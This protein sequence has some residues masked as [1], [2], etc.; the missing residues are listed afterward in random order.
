[1]TT[2]AQ[3]ESRLVN[4]FNQPLSPVLARLFRL[5][6]VV[7]LGLVLIIALTVIAGFAFDIQW[8]KHPFGNQP[9]LQSGTAFAFLFASIAMLLL[10]PPLRA[11]VMTVA[12]KVMGGVVFC[13]GLVN[14]LEH[15]YQRDWSLSYPL[16]QPADATPLTFP[17]PIAPDVSVMFMILGVGIALIGLDYKNKLSLSQAC[18]LLV[19]LPNLMILGCYGFGVPHI[20]GFFGCLKFSPVTAFVFAATTFSALLSRP[21]EGIVSILAADTTGGDLVR[22]IALCLL[23][24]VP[25]LALIKAGSDMEFYDPI[26]AY[27]LMALLFSVVVTG[28]VMRSIKKVDSLEAEKTEIFEKLT[29]SLVNLEVAQKLRLKTVCLV[30]LK[31]YDD[32]SFLTCP[33]DGSELQQILDE[34]KPGSVF[35]TNYEI[36]RCLGA[37]GMSA[38]YL[39]KHKHMETLVAIKLVHAQFASDPKYVQRFKREAQATRALVHPHIAQTHDFGISNQGLAYLVMDFIDGI[40]LADRVEDLGPMPWQ[41]AVTIFLQICQGL[42]FAHANNIVHR[43]LKPANIMLAKP[44]TKDLTAKIVDFGL[45]KAHEF[46]SQKLTRTGEVLGSPIYMSPEQCRGEIVDERSDIYSMGTL[47]YEVLTGGPPFCGTTIFDTLNLQIGALPPEMPVNLDIPKWLREVVFKALEKAPE[48]RQQSIQGMIDEINAG[49]H[50]EMSSYLE[51][52]ERNTLS[53]TDAV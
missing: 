52:I 50:S 53:G 28:G 11:S 3:T 6:A 45:A 14:F 16:W 27:G 10:Y 36:D 46:G 39:A 19:L 12:A 49:M 26:I 23:P 13:L 25:A 22:Y 9:S 41:E 32:A 35:A 47:M 38:V 44:G 29:S 8:I 20:C 33:D 43:D 5:L 51:R 31:E 7:G 21:K 2:A 34:L 1:M 40:N 15:S 18:M 42:K 17:G 48:H 30:C 24:L 4:A 37:G